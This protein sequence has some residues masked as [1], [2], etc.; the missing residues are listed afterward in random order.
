MKN[1]WKLQVET[2]SFRYEIMKNKP[3]NNA[4]LNRICWTWTRKQPTLKSYVK[5]DKLRVAIALDRIWPHLLVHK[6]LIKLLG[7]RSLLYR[8][9]YKCQPNDSI[10]IA[11]NDMVDAVDSI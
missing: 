4:T 7:D 1:K 2:N 3:I 11:V 5:Q 6:Q 9:A 8:Q 10:G